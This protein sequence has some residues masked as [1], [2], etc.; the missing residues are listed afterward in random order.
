MPGVGES[1][2]SGASAGS[3]AGPWG[4]LAGGVLGGV[5]G[6]F[7]RHAANKWLKNNPFPVEQLPSEITENQNLA[8]KEAATG[9]PSEQ[10]AK[11]MQDI[12][13]QQLVA[14]RSSSDRRGGLGSLPGILQGTNDATLN[15]N[16]T[17]AGM[18]LAN[19]RNLMNVNNQVAGWKSS[20]FD[21]NV[22]SKYNRDYEYNMGLKGAGDQNI[23]GGADKVLSGLFGGSYTGGKGLFTNSNTY[24]RKPT[25][26]NGYNENS[27]YSDFG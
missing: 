10:Y 1:A 8:R 25:Y 7:Q 11:A 27:N 12:Q 21:R 26:Y 15:L 22:R 19:E 14:L 13:R 9:L 17:D 2:L 5:V 3:A 20:L 4:A 23:V 18:K 16:A 24:S 6:L